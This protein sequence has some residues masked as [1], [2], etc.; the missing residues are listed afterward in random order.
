MRQPFILAIDTCEWCSAPN[1]TWGYRDACRFFYPVDRWEAQ[2]LWNTGVEHIVYIVLTVAHI[3]HDEV[4]CD[5]KNL[6][7][8]CQMCHN[9]HDVP[10]RKRTRV[11][12]RYKRQLREDKLRGQARIFE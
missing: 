5:D 7:A 8:L 10:H 9:R 1:H 6:A 3:D 12:T 11:V 4:N 2:W